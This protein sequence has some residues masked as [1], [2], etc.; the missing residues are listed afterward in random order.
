[1]T[2]V[3]RKREE[4]PRHGVDPRSMSA[5][6]IRENLNETAVIPSFEEGY[7][8]DWDMMK[9]WSDG[10]MLVRDSFSVLC[11]RVPVFWKRWLENSLR[12]VSP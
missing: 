3:H 8:K 12:P 1:M 4:D 10:E 11:A 7:Y 2:V 6:R 5:I 9:A